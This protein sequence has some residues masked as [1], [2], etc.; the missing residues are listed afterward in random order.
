M[1][2]SAP[3]QPVLSPCVGVCTLDD[4]DRCLGCL[5]TADEIAGWASFSERERE[6]IMEVLEYRAR[7]SGSG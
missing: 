5:R 2:F 6:R 7:D 3:N 1:S 4:D